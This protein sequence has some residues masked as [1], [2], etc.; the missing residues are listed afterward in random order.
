MRE[1]NTKSNEDYDL[2]EIEESGELIIATMSGPDTYYDYQGHPMG[3]Q[4]A[5]AADFA[6][7]EGLGVRVETAHDTLELIKMLQNGDADIIAPCRCPL[8]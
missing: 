2:Q 6:N 5:L 1:E 3:L 8:G 7:R 4:Y